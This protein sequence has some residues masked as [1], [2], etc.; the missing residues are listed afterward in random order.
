MFQPKNY[1]NK[2]RTDV[3]YEQRSGEQSLISD[4]LLQ[5]IEEKIRANRRV[6]IREFHHFFPG[7]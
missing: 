3:Q 7:V 6:M 1:N 2:G 4:D 5:E